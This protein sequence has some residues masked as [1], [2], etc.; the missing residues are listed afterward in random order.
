ML[1]SLIEN[2]KTESGQVRQAENVEWFPPLYGLPLISLTAILFAT[3]SLVT[4]L[5]A[6]EG[7]RGGCT[8]PATYS[9]SRPDPAGTP[10]EVAVGLYVVDINKI[11]DAAQ[12]FFADFR[13]ELRWRD[14]RLSKENSAGSRA[15]CKY[16]LGEIWNP[17]VRILNG[18]NLKKQ[19]EDVVE[20]TEDGT[21]K[22]VQRFIGQFSSHLDLKDFPLDSQTLF[23]TM[24][25]PREVLFIV[26]PATTGQ[27]D[28][29]TLAEW[30]IDLGTA[31]V[32][33]FY[34]AA[35]N[36]SLSRV[37]YRLQVKRHTGYYLWKILVPLCLI[38]VMSWAVFWID[39]TELGAQVGVSTA[40][41]L[42]LFA[43]QF[44]FGFVLPKVSYLT[45][46]DFFVLGSTILVFLA[47]AESVFTSAL[48]G[49]GKHSRAI[50][51]DRW[52][53]FSFAVVLIIILIV[54]F[55]R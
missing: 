16:K 5:S 33:S 4:A 25:A 24:L 31:I 10:T 20:V 53:R 9:S 45:R 41:V 14:H 11:D 36:I 2:G 34:I 28:R 7:Y 51:I 30:S 29:F 42:T 15:G 49:K 48:A 55:L 1:L 8:I 38:V 26:D 3:A 12:M 52:S 39:P 40:S 54:S 19:F 35:Q 47:L 50:R 18:P 6:E 23:F 44:S 37:D 13:L 46:L 27:R 43:F 21:V 32:D 17:G 22:Y